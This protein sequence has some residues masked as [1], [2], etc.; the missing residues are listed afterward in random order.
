MYEA[1]RLSRNTLRLNDMAPM[2][3]VQCRL[4]SGDEAFE[5]EP[6][7]LAAESR[8]S[9]VRLAAA[10]REGGPRAAGARRSPCMM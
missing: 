5:I 10:G 4:R 2:P 7:T 8:R 1:V 6:L 3:N 9:G